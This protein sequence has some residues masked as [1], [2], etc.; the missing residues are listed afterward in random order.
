MVGVWN[1]DKRRQV[2]NHI[3]GSKG[4]PESISVADITGNNLDIVP[5]RERVEP[6][7]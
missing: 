1:A 3:H 7:P 2:K 5:V 4:V 6:T